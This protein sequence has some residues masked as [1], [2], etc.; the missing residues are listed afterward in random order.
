[1]RVLESR[2]IYLD[3]SVE[4]FLAWA[5]A[6][7]KVNG[8]S[9][10]VYIWD[11]FSSFVDRNRVELKTLEQLA[12]AAQQGRFLFRA[13]DAHGDFVVY[14]GGLRKREESKRPFQVQA[15]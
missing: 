4:D 9:K 7:L 12:E 6:A 2:H 14:R 10:L 5:S 11:E 15:A 3:L 13:G 8:L 1:M